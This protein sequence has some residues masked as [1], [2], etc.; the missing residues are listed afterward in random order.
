VR[1]T[2]PAARVR[3]IVTGANAVKLRVGA[4][5]A[6]PADPAWT[7]PSSVTSLL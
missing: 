4:A 2:A 5:S 7:P 1:T 3:R 6:V